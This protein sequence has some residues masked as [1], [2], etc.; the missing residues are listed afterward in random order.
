MEICI[1][2]CYN[3]ETETDQWCNNV[4]K[5]QCIDNENDGNVLFGAVVQSD[6]II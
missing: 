5:Q 6:K 2:D 1:I 4:M 3:I